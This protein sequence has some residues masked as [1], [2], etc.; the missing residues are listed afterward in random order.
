MLAKSKDAKQQASIKLAP[1]W[2]PERDN[3]TGAIV[4][5]G[6]L[7][8]FIET[9]ALSRREGY[10][11]LPILLSLQK[12]KVSVFPLSLTPPQKKPPRRRDRKH[13]RPNPCRCHRPCPVRKRRIRQ[14]HR[15]ELKPFTE[16]K[17]Q[18]RD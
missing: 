15:R 12:P 1:E 14:H 9:I 7:W 18:E 17:P 3:E 13:P 5:R 10:V 6:K 8:D 16:E 4:P 11:F 2:T